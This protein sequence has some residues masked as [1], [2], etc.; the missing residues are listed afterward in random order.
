MSL[1]SDNLAR[2]K[3]V[4]KIE[5]ISDAQIEALLSFKQT[6]Y[7][8]LE[9]DGHKYPAWRTL[10]SEALGPGKG[11]IRFHPE[12]S[13]DEIDSLAFWMA[14]KNSLAGIPYGGAKGGIK[15]NPKETD[16]TTIEKISRA[17]IRAFHDRLGQDKDIPAPDVYT[18]SRIM[19]WM[20][21]EYET[22]IG[23]HEPG[24]ITGKPEE[25]GG[26]SMRTDATAEGAFLVIKE[27]IGDMISDK[28]NVRI[29]I[30]GFGNAGS[31]L[32][33][34]L[35]GDGLKIVAISDSMGGIINNDGLDIRSA[36]SWKKDQGRL[37]GFLGSTPISN[38]DLLELPVDIL[39]LA[40]LE[41]QIT[42]VN[43]GRVQARYLVEVANG[44]V[45]SAADDILYLSG[46]VVVPDILAN[47]GGVIVSYFEWAQNRTGQ[48]IPDDY[49]R[50]VLADKMVGNWKRIKT[51]ADDSKV[52]LRIAAYAI[53]LAKIIKA[54]QWR[55]HIVA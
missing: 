3:A 33:S 19:S 54:E 34:K 52:S 43:V 17:Y 20:L 10:F 49:L 50:Q 35:A 46:Q 13:E 41:N 4:Q 23:R 31:F 32:A 5:K 25:L 21:D 47:A 24:M 16:I 12:V 48:I 28:R 53:A 26:I 14:L 40:A 55:G 7:S 9:V 30:Q 51:K 18:N 1:F 6:A 8:E 2:L 15:F 27:M 44:P 42:E 36:L 11:G 37:E 29:A 39:V 45:S 38:N 22:I